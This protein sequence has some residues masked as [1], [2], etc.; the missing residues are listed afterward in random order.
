MVPGN[1]GLTVHDISERQIY[2]NNDTFQ[3]CYTDLEQ[4][5]EIFIKIFGKFFKDGRM[6]S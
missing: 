1:L 5:D 6:T 2:I 4:V 3:I